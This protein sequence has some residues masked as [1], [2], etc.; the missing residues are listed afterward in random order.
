MEP[1]ST[2]QHHADASES[3]SSPL[4]SPSHSLF[5]FGIDDDDDDEAM[6]DENDEADQADVTEAEADAK[7]TDEIDDLSHGHNAPKRRKRNTAATAQGLEAVLHTIQEQNWSFRDFIRTWVGAGSK[8]DVEIISPKSRF[9]R[10]KAQRR[11]VLTKIVEE[12]E[13]DGSIQITSLP[14]G[15]IKSISDELDALIA[16]GNCF[17]VFIKEDVNPS[18]IEDIDFEN[19]GRTIE[20]LAPK[21]HTLLRRLMTNQRSHWESYKPDSPAIIS[22]RVFMVTAMVCFSKKSRTSNYFPRLLAVYLNEAGTER[23]VLQTLSELGLCPAYPRGQQVW[24]KSKKTATT[25]EGMYQILA[26]SLNS[27]TITDILV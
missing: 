15:V 4:S 3:P 9:Y 19:A 10:T 20:R 26:T 16:A 21:W 7:D 14:S 25:S 1:I 17:G 24:D 27:W 8:R 23:K 6:A 5:D 11:R 18:S 12:L 22:K 2:L 13:S